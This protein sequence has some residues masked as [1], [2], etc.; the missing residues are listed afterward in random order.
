M[1]NTLN[2]TGLVCPEDHSEFENDFTFW[3]DGVTLCSIAIP[4]ILL[5]LTAI[6]IITRN[7]ELHHSFNYFLVALFIFD[8]TYLFTTIAN[9]SFM[10]QFGMATKLYIRVYP[11]LM[12]P[13][14]HISFTCS[15][16][17]TLVISYERYLAIT[18]PIQHHVAMESTFSRRMKLLKYV[19]TVV[20][21]AVL[22]NVPKFME[23]CIHRQNLD[24][25]YLQTIICYHII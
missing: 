25:Y 6:F 16:F 8:S 7:K 13:L 22:F 24:R 11:H 21:A 19:L 10:K 9:Q 23:A 18:N 14:K 15:I 20:L 12:H 2:D 3:V 5:N 1:N 17:M 4:G